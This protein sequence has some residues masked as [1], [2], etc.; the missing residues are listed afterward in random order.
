MSNLV[1]ID[2]D[3]LDNLIQS[4][5]DMKKIVRLILD[6]K[7]SAKPS[8]LDKSLE[9]IDSYVPLKVGLNKLGISYTTWH[10]KHQH[11]IRW[12]QDGRKQWLY[13][14]SIEQHLRKDNLNE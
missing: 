7:P 14:P 2:S 6:N 5:E 10:R 12:K 4:V 3:K 11:F 8:K 1:L 9:E 13:L